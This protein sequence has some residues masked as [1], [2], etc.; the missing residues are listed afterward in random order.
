MS[1]R[2]DEQKN[3]LP[4]AAKQL[5][6][7][8]NLGVTTPPPM[9]REYD[10]LAF[11]VDRSFKTIVE[12]A[13]NSSY[14]H[15]VQGHIDESKGLSAEALDEYRKA[16]DHFSAGRLLAQEFHLPEAA[17]E[18]EAALADEPA[19]RLAAAELAQVYVQN[20]Q[21]GKA[22]PLLVRL[23]KNYPQDAYAWA[24]LGR[25]EIMAG[26]VEQGIRSLQTALRLNPSL[27]NVHYEL[28][29]AYRQLGRA[30]LAEEE[31]KTFQSHQNPMP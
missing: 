17:A 27:N 25:A 15:R 26:Q 18:L 30:R 10:A 21:A 12:T 8:Q 9:I 24:D 2:L 3:D 20:H 23:L 11:L 31:I 16:Q 6:E 22:V 29:M 4:G 28:A 5:K 14:S 19:N 13:P 1:L 7:I